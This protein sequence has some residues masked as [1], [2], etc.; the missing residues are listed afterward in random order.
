[1]IERDDYFVAYLVVSVKDRLFRVA[2]IVAGAVEDR[3][4]LG[5]RLPRNPAV[6]GRLEEGFGQSEVITIFMKRGVGL[7]DRRKK[8]PAVAIW[9]EATARRP[10]RDV[11]LFREFD[12][13]RLPVESAVENAETRGINVYEQSLLF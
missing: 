1:L 6:S 10:E 2:Q 3:F 12:S 5:K 8:R 11:G 4:E 7:G 13:E 9:Q